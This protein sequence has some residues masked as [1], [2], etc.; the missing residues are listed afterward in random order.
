KP[1]RLYLL[2]RSHAMHMFIDARATLENA[3]RT[4]AAAVER[5]NTAALLGG[6]ARGSL[7]RVGAVALGLADFEGGLGLGNRLVDSVKNFGVA[8]DLTHQRNGAALFIGQNVDVVRPLDHVAAAPVI[9]GNLF[10]DAAMMIVFR[11]HDRDV[12]PLF[13]EPLHHA[14]KLFDERADQIVE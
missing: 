8:R 11:A 14:I 6:P 1:G 12:E 9:I 13:G 2:F 5:N 4:T 10:R 3:L 7:T